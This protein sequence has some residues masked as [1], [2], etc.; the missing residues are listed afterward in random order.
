MIILSVL[1]PT[2][3]SRKE[4]FARLYDQIKKQADFIAVNWNETVEILFDDSPR[5]LEGGLSIGKKR[6]ALVRRAQGKYLCLLDDDDTIAPNYLQALVLL[7]KQGRDVCTFRNISK[8]DYFWT[9]IDMKLHHPKN[10]QATHEGIVKRRPWH[11]CPIKSHLAKKHLFADISYGED[12]E[13]MEKILDECHTE[14]TTDAII[15]QYNFNSKQSEA[16]KITQH[17]TLAE[18]RGTGNP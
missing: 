16:D 3:P 15:H 14:A 11:I 12:W 13:W 18:S 5:F 8:L 1:I 7:C 2:I 17:G 6:E 4:Q 10:E 9:V